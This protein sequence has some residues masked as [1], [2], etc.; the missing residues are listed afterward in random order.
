MKNLSVECVT[1]FKALAEGDEII[2]YKEN[3]KEKAVAKRS[4][5]IAD[6]GGSSKKARS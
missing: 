2:I 4:V 6:V 1:N 5:V 3:K